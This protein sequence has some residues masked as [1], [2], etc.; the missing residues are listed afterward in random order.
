ML[1]G[2]KVTRTKRIF[3]EDARHATSVS[4]K[5]ECTRK[6]HSESATRVK[7]EIDK[8]DL[9]RRGKHCVTGRCSKWPLTGDSPIKAPEQRSM[10]HHTTRIANSKSYQSNCPIERYNLQ[11]FRLSM[12]NL[13]NLS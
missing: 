8:L 7:T 3:R 6:I 11:V 10:M 5:E 9:W 12:E 1:K 13:A 2:E 4:G